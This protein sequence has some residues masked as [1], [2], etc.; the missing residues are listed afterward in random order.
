MAGRILTCPRE[1]VCLLP[2]FIY[3]NA[4]YFSPSP[5]VGFYALSKAAVHGSVSFQLSVNRDNSMVHITVLGESLASELQPFSIRVLIVQ[6]GLFRTEGIFRYRFDEDTNPISDYDKL[7]EASAAGYHAIS[8][9]QKGDPAKGAELIVDVVRGEGAARG[10][11]WPLYLVLGED[12]EQDVRAKC[13]KVLGALD[14][15]RD[16]STSALNLDEYQNGL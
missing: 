9:T 5:F 13:G 3:A 15:W 10:R 1:W 8:G 6:P 7:R 16:V 4:N 14:K 11:D 2:R 12:A